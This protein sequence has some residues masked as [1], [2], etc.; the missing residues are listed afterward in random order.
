MQRR[1]LRQA[2]QSLRVHLDFEHLAQLLRMSR[3]CESGK[4][5]ALPD[6]W[7]GMREQQ[8]LRFD[9]CAHARQAS[10]SYAYTLPIPGEVEVPELGRVIR[11]FLRP[12][13]SAGSGYNREQA[14]DPAT[15]GRELLVRNWQPGDRFWL[16]HSKAP[17]KLKELFEQRHVRAAERG[18]WPVAISGGKLAWVRGFGASA[19]FQPTDDAGQV[20]VIEEHVAHAGRE[21]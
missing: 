5:C 3:I 13:Q 12:L 18:A 21:R 11:A 9:R 8:E 15:L 2:A 6:G 1:I 17:K 4:T 19:E 20:V 16:V 10:S 14:L 7:V